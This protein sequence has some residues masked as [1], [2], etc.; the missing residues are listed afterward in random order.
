MPPENLK[1]RCRETDFEGI[2][3]WKAC[4]YIYLANAYVATKLT[5]IA[6]TMTVKQAVTASF[7][8]VNLALIK[9]GS[10]FVTHQKILFKFSSHANMTKHRI[11]WN[12]HPAETKRST[13]LP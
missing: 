9:V 7:Q 4:R 6:C 3:P 5:M 8:Y 13:V 1:T 11:R 2:L 12:V 10:L